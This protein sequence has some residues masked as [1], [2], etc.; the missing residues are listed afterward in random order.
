MPSC[1]R[2]DLPTFNPRRISRRRSRWRRPAFANSQSRAIG[3]A[4]GCGWGEG[5]GHL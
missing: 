1:V 5:G 3:M 2:F 4:L